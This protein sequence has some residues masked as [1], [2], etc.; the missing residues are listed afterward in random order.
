MTNFISQLFWDSCVFYAF[1]ADDRA[2][3]DVDS[4]AQYLQEAREGKHRIYA[5]TL[6][7]AEVIP[8]AIKKPDVGTFQN[9]ID[10][11]Q[12]AVV[13]IDPTPNIMLKAAQLKDLPYRK[14]NSKARRLSTPDAIILAKNI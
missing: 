8:S 13:L 1:L 3:Y 6:V 10:D 5:S 2:S 9:F 11:L 7:L 12:G 14:A 4:I